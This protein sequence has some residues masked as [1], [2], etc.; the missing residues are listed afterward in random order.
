MIAD[1]ER[2]ERKGEG[3]RELEGKE[4]GWE[5]REEGE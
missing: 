1:E 5:G 3:M 2:V 4:G